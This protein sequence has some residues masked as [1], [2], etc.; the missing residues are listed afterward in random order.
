M[1]MQPSVETKVHVFDGMPHGFY[2]F[3]SCPATPRW[4]EVM[5]EAIRWSGTSKDEWIIEGPTPPKP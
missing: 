3:D 1:L 5:R 2:I 4:E